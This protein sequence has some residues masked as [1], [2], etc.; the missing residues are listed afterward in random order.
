MTAGSKRATRVNIFEYCIGRTVKINTV[1]ENFENPYTQVLRFTTISVP[2]LKIFYQFQLTPP[3]SASFTDGMMSTKIER[4]KPR[5]SQRDETD[6]AIAYVKR[7][8]VAAAAA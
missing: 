6:R 4:G 1:S 7:W 8:K 2:C 5:S 3:N